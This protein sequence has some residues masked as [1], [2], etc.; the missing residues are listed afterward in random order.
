MQEEILR[1]E[2]I[3]NAIVSGQDKELYLKD[4]IEN[5]DPKVKEQKI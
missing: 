2:M 1:M 4:I 3:R 5:Q